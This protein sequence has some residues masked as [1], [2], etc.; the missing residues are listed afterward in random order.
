[1]YDTAQNN[2]GYVN[3]FVNHWLGLVPRAIAAII[4]LIIFW[5]LAKALATLV[6]NL[7]GRI[8]FNQR[9]HTTTG[10]NFIQ[11]AVPNPMGLVAGLVY[12]IV[13][14]FGISVVVTML[15]IPALMEIVRGIYTYIPHVIAAFI[16]FLVAGAV[17]GAV[18]KLV[19]DTM[20]ETPTGKVVGSAVPVVIMTIAGFM[21][22]N[23]LQFA[24]G[25]VLLTYG[26]ILGGISLGMAL[27]FGLGGRDVAAR[28][29]GDLYDK[30]QA[31]KG[32]VAADM[33]TGAARAKRKGEDLRDQAS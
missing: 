12:W 30:A 22:L 26:I 24:T 14:L 31:N 6:H 16:I 27:A 21:I 13:L 4:V 20:G 9:L 25:I 23:E 29:L 1:M 32:Q 15:G 7:L 33:K 5:L 10:G 2:T 11:R 8:G 18:G 17:A 28:M 3:N 19:K